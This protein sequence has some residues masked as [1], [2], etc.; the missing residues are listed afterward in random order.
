MDGVGR[1]SPFTEA[2]VKRITTSN[3]DILTILTDV[4]NDVVRVTNEKQVPWEHHALR[5]K[6]YFSSVPAKDNESKVQ[7]LNAQ[8][9]SPVTVSTP[10]DMMQ[11]LSGRQTTVIDT[12]GPV[13]EGGALFRIEMQLSANLQSAIIRRLS[14]KYE[15]LTDPTLE[16]RY[17]LGR[18]L[19]AGTHFA[20]AP[21]VGRYYLQIAQKGT[22]GLLIDQ[23][24][25]RV[26]LLN[27]IDNLLQT[28]EGSRVI[29][30]ERNRESTYSIDVGLRFELNQ[31]SKAWVMV[32]GTADG[33]DFEVTSTTFLVH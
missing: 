31:I 27:S 19:E 23:E 6:F 13:F 4:R 30:L 24:G 14:I 16:A 11:P 21:R 28:Q 5:G 2:L 20:G 9:Q 15:Q 25:R 29:T 3:D 12:E 1:N 26:P 7:V 17:Q 10:P 32:R 22:T 33:K 18:K 8:G